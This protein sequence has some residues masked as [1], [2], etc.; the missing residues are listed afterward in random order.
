MVPTKNAVGGDIGG[1]DPR[2]TSE[3][4]LP[5]PCTDASF[6]QRTAKRWKITSGVVSLCKNKETHH[7]L[8][9]LS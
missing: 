3:Q 6:R 1:A 9:I 7:F 8:K 5:A 4:I 2:G